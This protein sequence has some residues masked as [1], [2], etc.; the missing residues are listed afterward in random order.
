MLSQ[1]DVRNYTGLL[2][3]LWNVHSALLD[4]SPPIIV[5]VLGK[6]GFEDH[7]VGAVFSGILIS[8]SSVVEL[9]R[10]SKRLFMRS[11]LRS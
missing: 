10:H 3:T 8:P 6:V 5:R 2:S 7:P 4:S 1:I 11:K 9:T